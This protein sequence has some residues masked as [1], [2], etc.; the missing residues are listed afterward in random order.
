MSPSE[1]SSLLFDGTCTWILVCSLV[2][3]EHTL[4]E[5]KTPISVLQKQ[6]QLLSFSFQWNSFTT[7]DGHF[8]VCTGIS[9]WGE[10]WAEACPQ[11]RSSG[12]HFFLGHSG[13]LLS[14]RSI[15][16]TPEN[17]KAAVVLSSAVLVDIPL[18]ASFAS[19][20]S[21][22]GSSLGQRNSHQPPLPPLHTTIPLLE[23]PSCGLK[24]RFVTEA[25]DLPDLVLGL[26]HQA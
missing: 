1:S 16:P 23:H 2:F 15:L 20:A 22:P 21:F 3:P 18:S 7:T 10:A 14:Y 5:H 11:Q 24:D 8:S 26:S 13:K 12:W 25:L 9:L 4:S 6:A 19:S 17:S